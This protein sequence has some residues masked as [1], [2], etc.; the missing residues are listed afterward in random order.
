MNIIGKVSLVQINVLND[1]KVF[2]DKIYDGTC[3][4]SDENK[5][6]TCGK[7]I[8]YNVL[9]ENEITQLNLGL[10]YYFDINKNAYIKCHPRCKTCS[11]EY[12]KENMYC[13]SCYD[14]YFIR[15]S[16]CLET[17]YCEKNFFYDN[18]LNLKCVNKTMPCPDDKP[19]EMK[20]SKECIETCDL[21][22]FN[23]KCNPTNNIISINQTYNLLLENINNLNLNKLFKDQKRYIIEGSNVSFIFTTTKFEKDNLFYYTNTSSVLLNDCENTLKTKYS[24]PNENPLTILKIEVTNNHSDYMNVY[25]EVFNPTNLSQKLDLNLCKTSTIEIRVP[26]QIKKYKLDLINKTKELGYD[27]FNKDDPFYH[28]ICSV[29]TY[30][31]SDLSLSERKNILD[32]SDENFCMK[33]CNYSNMDINTIRSICQC[34]INNNSYDNNFTNINSNKL[35]NDDIYN[36]IKQSLNFDKTS[37]IKVVKCISII[38]TLNIFKNNYGF[39]I[40]FLTNCLNI[41]LLF[42]SPLSVVEK[43][44]NSFCRKILTQLKNIYRLYNLQKNQVTS[45]RKKEKKVKKVKKNDKLKN[46]GN[47]TDSYKKFANK[48]ENTSKLVCI[49]PNR[50]VDIS[51]K[52]TENNNSKKNEEKNFEILRNENN[53]KYYIEILIKYIPFKKRIKYLSEKEVQNLPYKYAIEIDNRNKGN[54]YY[55]LLKEKNKVISIFLN[56][57]DYNIAI[58]KISLF[59]FTFNLSFTVNALFFN[60]E[61]IYQINQENGSFNLNGQISKVLYSALIS[62][63]ISFIV[64]FCAL[65]HDNVIEIRNY[66]RIKD[67]DKFSKKIVKKLKIKFIIF[68]VINISLN[69]LFLYYITAFCA[70]YSSIQTHMISDS[71]IS[72]LMSISYSILLSIIVTLFRSISLKKNNKLN[73]FLYLL[74]WIISLI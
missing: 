65:T 26:V 52:V 58:V 11:K 17:S 44:F 72:F 16:T 42:F 1:I 35:G 27:I 10:N 34:K 9:N 57:D 47:I 41:I 36:L 24:I 37:N 3:I 31:N 71:L 51:R 60:D 74:S 18:D 30:N 33:G 49:N 7:S 53:S 40:I 55:S 63:I 23:S 50:N 6:I 45:K 20:S 39:Y 5:C 2:C 64:E 15:N 4:K 59:I 8:F 13:D 14:N 12:N 62:I 68:F 54:F 19:Y 21:D 67:A 46:Y 48:E 28:D 73:H 61:A 29:F 56:R 69:L 22:E 70:V 38:F 25:Y 66:K 32:L 43:N